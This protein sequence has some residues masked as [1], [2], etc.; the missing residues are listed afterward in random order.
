MSYLRTQEKYATDEEMLSAG[1]ALSARAAER[2]WEFHRSRSER[3]WFCPAGDDELV[4]AGFAEIEKEA[5]YDVLVVS[6]EGKAVSEMIW[7]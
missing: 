2:L 4:E 7:G 5:G 1:N 3:V 6:K